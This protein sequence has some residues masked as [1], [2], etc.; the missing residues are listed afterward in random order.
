[1]KGN[2]INSSNLAIPYISERSRNIVFTIVAIGLGI[3]FSRVFHPVGLGPVFLP[4]FL[5]LVILALVASPFY[6]LSA[7]IITP[8]LSTGM[9]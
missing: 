6:L 3:T 4:M 1:M 8:L 5:P 2:I 9:E 7:A